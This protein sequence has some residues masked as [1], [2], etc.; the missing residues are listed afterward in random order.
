MSAPNIVQTNES[1]GGGTPVALGASPSDQ[2]GAYGVTPVTQ[3]DA[4]GVGAGNATAVVIDTTFT[5]GVGAS[6][7]T[8]GDIVLALKQ[9]GLIAM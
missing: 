4:V 9:L 5:G 1:L 8:L 6:A 2:I 7:Y 3:P